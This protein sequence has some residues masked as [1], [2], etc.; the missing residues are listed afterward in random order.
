MKILKL[1]CFCKI[2]LKST[3]FTGSYLDFLWV[4]FSF[5]ILQFYSMEYRSGL[6]GQNFGNEISGIEDID[7]WKKP[8][9]GKEN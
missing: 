8:I 1:N 7:I 4:L 2:K 3:F 5:C 6:V 9:F